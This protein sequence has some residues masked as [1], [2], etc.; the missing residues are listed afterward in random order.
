MSV[1]PPLHVFHK[2]FM[3][4]SFFGGPKLYHQN[5]RASKACQINLATS[6]LLWVCPKMKYPTI[7]LVIIMLQSR[8]Q[9]GVHTLDTVI[10]VSFEHPMISHVF[11]RTTSTPGFSTLLARLHSSWTGDSRGYSLLAAWLHHVSPHPHVGS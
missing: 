3:S 9:F 4:S 6:F 10:F 5:L 7:Q 11:A 8:S 2:I 1:C